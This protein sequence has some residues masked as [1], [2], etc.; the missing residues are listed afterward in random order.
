M[1]GG[2][3]AVYSHSLGLSDTVIHNILPVCR[4]VIHF[5]LEPHSV[6]AIN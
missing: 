1:A 6:S 5:C 2:G 3:S 4:R